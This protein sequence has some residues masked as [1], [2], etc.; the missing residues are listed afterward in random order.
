MRPQPTI[1]GDT[2]GQGP[3]SSRSIAFNTDFQSFDQLL[4]V[5]A[6]A[7][8]PESMVKKVFAFTWSSTSVRQPWETDYEAITR[9]IPT[10]ARH[11]Y[12]ADYLRNSAGLVVSCR[13]AGEGVAPEALLLQHAQA[14]LAQEEEQNEKRKKRKKKK[15]KTKS[16]GNEDEQSS[17]W[18]KN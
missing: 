11:A 6:A 3:T 2:S 17:G 13:D 10:P 12:I 8:R 1:A 7:T 14:F 9:S 16:R 5:A 15:N 4:H 18:R